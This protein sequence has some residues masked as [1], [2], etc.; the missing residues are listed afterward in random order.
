MVSLAVVNP[1]DFCESF[2]L[3][4]DV[5]ADDEFDGNGFDELIDAW[6]VV[7]L[8]EG[9]SVCFRKPISGKL[10]SRGSRAET[11]TPFDLNGKVLM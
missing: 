9:D 8:K 5:V 2:G 4:D 10:M 11:V 7:G 3:D 1:E 6:M